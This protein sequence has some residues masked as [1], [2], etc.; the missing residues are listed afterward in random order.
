MRKDKCR[1]YV[2]ILLHAGKFEFEEESIK[3]ADVRQDEYVI[4]YG[5]MVFVYIM[6]HAGEG[7]CAPDLKDIADGMEG[8]LVICNRLQN[9]FVIQTDEAEET[10]EE[11]L[12]ELTKRAPHALFGSRPWLNQYDEEQFEE[13]LKMVDIMKECIGSYN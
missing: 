13:I 9:F 12:R 1:K 7:Y 11:I 10:A 3:I 2:N 4:P 6:L 5:E 8:A